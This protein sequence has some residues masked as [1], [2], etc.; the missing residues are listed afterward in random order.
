FPGIPEILVGVGEVAAIGKVPPSQALQCYS[1]FGRKAMKRWSVILGLLMSL[2]AG[3]GIGIFVVVAGDLE[4]RSDPPG[5]STTIGLRKQLFV[6]DQV[7]AEKAGV[8]RELGQ[9]TK[10]NG[11]KPIYMDGTFYG[12]VLHDGGKF[13]LWCRNL[14][15]G[16][17]YAESGDGL[18]F[19]KK[20]DV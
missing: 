3:V 7:I 13:K 8:T 16:Y 18:R 9:V 19:E 4:R 12:T 14:G 20:V 1:S 6:D 10:A 11:G 5:R 17:G 2:L 15:P